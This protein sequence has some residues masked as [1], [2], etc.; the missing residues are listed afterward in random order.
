M[1]DTPKASRSQLEALWWL[2][3]RMLITR[4]SSKAASAEL[5]GEARKLLSNSG[6]IAERTAWSTRKL[7][8]LHSAYI[9]A[10]QAAVVSDKPSAAILCEARLYLLQTKADREALPTTHSAI[11][12]VPFH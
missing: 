7:D 3:L 9:T 8:T 12:S 10:L 2:C 1:S 5:L 6:Y 4:I 11:S